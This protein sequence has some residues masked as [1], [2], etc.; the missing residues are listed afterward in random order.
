[1]P[2]R[3]ARKFLVK[4]P[5][6][7]QL[8]EIELRSPQIIGED[9]ELWK[10]FIKKE[11]THWQKKNY[12]PRNDAN[13][14]E[15]YMRYKKEEAEELK[16]DREQL[17]NAM[18]KIYQEQKGNLSK[19][20]ESRFL[21]KPPKDPY[22][23]ANNGGV[24][25]SVRNKSGIPGRT[26]HRSRP[27]SYIGPAATGVKRRVNIVEKAKREAAMLCAARQQGRGNVPTF[28]TQI[29]KAP[30]SMVNE[31]Q[32]AAS[33][34]KK[35]RPSISPDSASLPPRNSDI[36]QR[37]AR[38]RAI[39]ASGAKATP[40]EP[41]LAPPQILDFPASKE[42]AATTIIDDGDDEIDRLFGEYRERQLTPSTKRKLHGND[43]ADVYVYQP[44]P[45]KPA[46]KRTSDIPPEEWEAQLAKLQSV[47]PP[48]SRPGSSH[49]IIGIKNRGTGS[50]PANAPKRYI[51]RPAPADPFFTPKKP[52]RA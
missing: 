38:L 51:K 37:E 31:Y 43:S 18:N 14:Y 49:G 45:V 52:R 12:Q 16:R 19:K 22:M 44:S 50:P 5:T 8:H 20:M 34:E 42:S 35:R 4:I 3:I 48:S 28:R 9:A 1:M 25:I 2:Y 46:T 13:W 33:E 26:T 40:K 29:K 11:I 15:V 6:A 24:P 23:L 36:E 32:R 39:K 10:K 30:A 7:N 41:Y 47:S 17:Q 21:P 27:I